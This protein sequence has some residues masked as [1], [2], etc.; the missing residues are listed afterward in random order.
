MKKDITRCV[1]GLFL[2]CG[3][4]AVVMMCLGSLGSIVIQQEKGQFPDFWP[5]LPPPSLDTKDHARKCLSQIC[6]LLNRFYFFLFSLA[7]F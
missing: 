3:H 2:V 7:S 6:F 5:G 1:A 4:K